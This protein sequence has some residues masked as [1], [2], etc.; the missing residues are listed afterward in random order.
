M[1]ERIDQFRRR[2][3]MYVAR[4]RALNAAIETSRKHRL[5]LT[6]MLA[7]LLVAV[8]VS[9]IGKVDR[10]ILVVALF[11]GAM[12]AKALAGMIVAIAFDAP[13]MKRIDIL[14]PDPRKREPTETIGAER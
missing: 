6:M 2:G 4:S 1:R 5:R 10:W 14:H 8:V 9:Q 3:E 7:I 13:T 12:C 11:G